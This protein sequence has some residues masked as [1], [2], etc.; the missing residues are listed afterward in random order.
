MQT[1]NQRIEL[2][3]KL[4]K[5]MISNDME[6]TDTK[7]KAR[8][9]N[10]WFTDE[11]I[12]TA[13]K[14]I[15]EQYLQQD[16]L[17]AWVADYNVP[18]DK[19]LVGIIMAGNI[20]LVGMHD[21]IC[22]FTS[23]HK[24]SIKLSSKDNVL[25]NHIIHKL[26]EWIPEL[27]EEISI[28][29]TLKGCDA[30]IMTGNNNSARYFEY[31]FGKYPNIIRKNRTSVAI[32]DGT[33]TEEELKELNKDIFTY[34]GL[35]CRNVSKIYLPENYDLN[36]LLKSTEDYKHVF[37]H[38]KYKNNFDYN[39]AIYLLNKEQYLTN[40][41]VILRKCE[42]IF[43]PVSVLNYEFYSDRNALIELLQKNDNVQCLVGSGY[44]P[45]G[46]AQT[47][48]LHSYADN[49]DTMLFLSQL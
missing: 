11:S 44:T 6:W 36:N 10:S 32:L 23:G 43:S 38:H 37:Q 7:V 25:F 26:K 24:L 39:L 34:Y 46:T 14:N 30:Y 9:A 18:N 16:K 42:D 27:K 29:D 45:F 33:E 4:G 41:V 28:T 12:D 15:T 35:G 8:L 21:F 20:P 31:Y 1:V 22:G 3:D 5:Y 40:E 47:P 17:K 2:L 19:K 48:D 13:I 49:V